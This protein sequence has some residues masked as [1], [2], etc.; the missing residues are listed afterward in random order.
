MNFIFS[1]YFSKPNGFSQHDCTERC[2]KDDFSLMEGWYTSL[3]EENLQS[4]VF[5]NELSD[6]FVEMFTSKNCKFLFHECKNRKSYNDE[7]FFCYL[8]YLKN[9][10]EIDKVMMTDMFD[11]SFCGNPFEMMDENDIYVGSEV[12]NAKRKWVKDKLKESNLP[13]VGM[14]VIYNAGIL[15]GDRIVMIRFLEDLCKVLRGCPFDVNANMGAFNYL[16]SSMNR[17]RCVE[18]IIKCPKIRTGL[19]LHNEFRTFKNPDNAYI[20]HK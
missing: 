14:P 2:K 16:L 12:K 9:H 7:R 8:N 13:V 17:Y 15:G 3:H 4:V 10:T 6:D 11:V 20:I 1:T 18:G 5:H 19:P